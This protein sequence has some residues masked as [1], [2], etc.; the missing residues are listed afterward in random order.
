[1]ANL[2]FIIIL[3]SFPA[4]FSFPAF[5]ITLFGGG[6]EYYPNS[7]G[8][9]F[10]QYLDINFQ[11]INDGLCVFDM[12][13]PNN[14]LLYSNE[15]MDFLENGVYYYD[16]KVPSEEGVYIVSAECKDPTQRIQYLA[17]NFTSYTPIYSQTGDYTYTWAFDGNNHYVESTLTN[18]NISYFFTSDTGG[19]GNIDW[20]GGTS[21]GGVFEILFL[22]CSSGNFQSLLSTTI[23]V[24]QLLHFSKALSGNFSCNGTLEI[25][26]RLASSGGRRANLWTDYMFF[27]LYNTSGAIQVVRGGG[28]VHVSN[29]AKFFDSFEAS[30]LSNHDYCLD[31]TT[32]RKELTVQKCID[33]LCYNIT[34]L[35]DTVCNYGCDTERNTCLEPP[36]IRWGYIVGL[37]IAGI[38]IFLVIIKLAVLR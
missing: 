38:I 5:A 7:Y 14:T 25:N 37:F 21:S 19:F 36:F 12:Y 9:I 26:L 28:E 10:F 23:P 20:Y 17:N 13:S 33:T 34:K 15:I 16:F 27:N 3:L 18:L 11:P 35:E 2:K 22:N 32:L 4:F 30:L 6:T 1:M 29:L 24:N 8:K 31:N